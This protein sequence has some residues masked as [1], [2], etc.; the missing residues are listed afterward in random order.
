MVSAVPD[1]FEQMREAVEDDMAEHSK[2]SKI[3]QPFH[4]KAA[5]DGSFEGG[6][7]GSV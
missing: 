1:I 5:I 7:R 2:G 4:A 6:I 3:Q